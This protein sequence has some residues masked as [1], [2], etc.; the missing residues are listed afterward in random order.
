[1][2][3]TTSC[4]NSYIFIALEKVRNLCLNVRTAKSVFI[5]IMFLVLTPIMISLSAVN[6]II[7][8]ALQGC[9]DVHVVQSQE[10]QLLLLLVQ[11]MT[12][13]KLTITRCSRI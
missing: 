1:M 12:N 8:R 13:L 3:Y 11:L 10:Q 5:S 6:S 7:V 2:R 4:Q 9:A